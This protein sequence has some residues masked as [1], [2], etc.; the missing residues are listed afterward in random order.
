MQNGLVILSSIGQQLEFCLSKVPKFDD[1][2]IQ[3]LDVKGLSASIPEPIP[4]AEIFAGSFTLEVKEKGETKVRVILEN[5][6]TNKTKKIH[7]SVLA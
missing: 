6:V 1:W 2:S 3:S 7:F 4:L 5:K